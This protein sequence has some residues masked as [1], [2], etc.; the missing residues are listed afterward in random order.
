VF[1]RFALVLIAGLVCLSGCLEPSKPEA[2]GGDG[3]PAV[4]HGGMAT[5]LRNEKLPDLE[6]VEPWESKY[7]FSL[8]MTTAHYEIYTTLFEPS[9]LRQVPS[10]M[11]SAYRSY[12]MQLPEPIET[13]SKF[14]IYLFADR[15]QWVDFTTIFTG[16]RAKLFC[17][18]KAGAYY[19]NGACVAYNIGPNRTFSA[20]SHEGWHQF[21]GCHFEYRLPSWLDEGV[22]TQ[23]EAARA[24]P[25]G[26]SFEPA[27]N[28]YRLQGL[29][30]T[31]GR[32]KAIRLRDL[33]AINPGEVLATDEADAVT[34]FYSQS[35][36]LV[37]F[38]RE[39]NNGALLDN[40]RR[41][42]LDGLKGD[43]PLD[44]V[45]KKVAED[46]NIPRT[47]LWNRIVGLSLFEK[48][49]DDDFDEIEREY[50]AFCRRL[51]AGE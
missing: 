17:K 43:W 6:S 16:E 9:M 7:E 21:N 27:W 3:R 11:E 40:Y 29:A 13:K 34:D 35:Y 1:R 37:R 22:A 2:D 25:G 41:L 39:S 15:E 48:Y 33:L 42:L 10:Y 18:I 45:S 23:F 44:E 19:D 5:Y 26:F 4:R 49:I 38:L 36:A 14:I 50:L 46:R 24:V 20:L 30:K 12:N 28:L 8:K 47:V 51:A 32:G 31:V